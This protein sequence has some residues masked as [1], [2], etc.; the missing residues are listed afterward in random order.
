MSDEKPVETP[1][2]ERPWWQKK[3]N[4]LA[5]LVT[6][7]GGLELLISQEV[8]TDPAMIGWITVGVGVIG[9]IARN[10]V[11]PIKT[12]LQKNK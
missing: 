8:V 3:T 11:E 2:D 12:M 6:L 9:L 4:I 5:M 1:V 10:L 7:A